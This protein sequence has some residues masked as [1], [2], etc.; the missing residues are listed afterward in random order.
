MHSP[1]SRIMKKKN[2]LQL[3]RFSIC[4]PMY[5][6]LQAAMRAHARGSLES[7]VTCTGI[8]ILPEDIYRLLQKATQSSI[9]LGERCP[10]QHSL[11]VHW[12]RVC[13]INICHIG[14]ETSLLC[15]CCFLLL[16]AQITFLRFRQS[17][18]N[19]INSYIV[20]GSQSCGA[21]MP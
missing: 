21:T 6:Q 5:L 17:I 10:Q 14:L 2:T 3:Y 15:E 13:H 1:A 11:Q 16:L 12:K 9:P 18:N 8:R 7:R 20:F 4:M 19:S